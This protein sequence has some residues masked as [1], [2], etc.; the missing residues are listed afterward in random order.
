MT[1]DERNVVG[2]KVGILVGDSEGPVGTKEG[3]KEQG[4]AFGD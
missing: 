2:T 3:E 1:V 4:I